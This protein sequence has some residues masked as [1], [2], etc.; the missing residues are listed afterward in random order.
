MSVTY[1]A[2]GVN[3]Q[4]AET[5]K[6][7][8][9]ELA[10]RTFSENVLSDIG[11]FGGFFRLD[12]QRYRDPVLVSSVDGV[13]TKL[14]IAFMTGMHHTVGE[15]LVNH[16]VN[17]L[18]TSGAEPLFFLDYLA[19][20]SLNPDVVEQILRGLVRGCE[21][22]GCVLLGG[23][24]AEMPDFYR[25]GEYDLA[26]T[27]VGVVERD[28]IIDGKAIQPGDVLIGLPSK[29]LHTN[30]YS[31]ARKV[32]FELKNFKPD[33]FIDELGCTVGEELLRVHRSYR[34]AILAVRNR[35]AIKGMA[36]I[37]GGGL[38]ANVGRIL[39]PGLAARI[40]WQAWDVPPI[41][42]FIQRCGNVSTEEM[43]RVFNMG[44]G[45]VFATT[46]EE[47][48]TVLA[49]LTAMGEKAAAI[50]EVVAAQGP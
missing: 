4:A 36:H 30:G 27:I 37:T 44:M 49:A 20:G 33:D 46:H 24:T 19:V 7:R 41:F 9:A 1:K 12:R 39:P 5:S 42:S 10:R 31:L 25:P 22:A 15:D 2:A 43:R 23:E 16:C 14:K 50:G 17:D 38:L 3:R 29:G 32:L 8:I 45:Y 48:D 26:G 21:N 6:R 18:M 47:A 11:L 28:E 34:N 40:D 35:V 13:G